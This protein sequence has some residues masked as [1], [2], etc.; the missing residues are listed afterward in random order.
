MGALF[1]LTFVV[2][3][4]GLIFA[5]WLGI[6]LVTRNVKYPV[7]WLTA[8]TLWS[9]AGIFLNVLL[10]INPPPQEPF[11]PNWLRFLFPFWSSKTLMGESIGW[12]QGWSIV[13]GIAFWHHASVIMRPGKLS[14]LRWVRILAGYAIAIFAIILQTNLGILVTVKAGNPLYLNSLQPGLW[15]PY[16]VILLV[17]LTISIV[18]NL[19][20]TRA[21]MPA[22]ISRKQLMVLVSATLVSGLAGPLPIAGSA[23]SIA[24]PIVALSLVIII[25]VGL[26]GFG[27]AYYSA[28]MEGRTIRLDFQYNLFLLGL[29]VL[30]YL[31]GSWILIRAYQAPTVIFVFIPLLAV[32]THS[33]MNSAYR[34]F[35]PLFFRGNTRKL[36]ADLRQQLRQASDG[37]QVEDILAEALKTLCASVDAT[38]GLIIIF[39]GKTLHKVA[40][41][42]WRNGL[43]K[44]KLADLTTD[45]VVYL[46]P[47]QFQP[48]LEDA[49]LLIPLYVE[50]D[51]LGAL[52]LGCPINGVQFASE[53]VEDLLDRSDQL[54]DVIYIAQLKANYMKQVF[55]MAE[56]RQLPVGKP[57]VTIPITVVESALR[58]LYDYSFLADSPLAELEI[59]RIR[60]PAV[61]Y[62]HLERGKI[63]HNIL[64]EALEKLCPQ[65]NIPRDPPPREWH[66]YLI[67][68]DAY[69][70][71]KPNRDIMSKLYI[72]EGTFNRTRRSAIRSVARA[73]WEM[74]IALV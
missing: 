45:D 28:S 10:A 54:A 47:G 52:L 35:D 36:R 18:V 43:A 44:L 11:W 56:T 32:I 19:V 14:I 64:L 39:K 22:T 27:V 72:S 49:S 42:H 23:Y 29:V 73:L 3:F 2:N 6:Y 7:A 46:S 63:V 25:P 62:T 67:L 8:L 57:M 41:Y 40:A 68:R 48:P 20:R 26:I 34:L 21:A 16:F 24:I 69:R 13:P 55:E 37:K 59:V 4:L 66:P 58:N 71:E 9:V 31:L 17:L 53:D 5:L 65:K 61:K 50:C 51:Q 15:Y 12:L 70:E 30:V 33:L 38:Y 60:L 1:Y 74:E